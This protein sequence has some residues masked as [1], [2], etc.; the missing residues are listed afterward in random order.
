MN[1]G[2]YGGEM[3]QVLLDAVVFLPEEGIRTLRRE[4]CTCATATA[5]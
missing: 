3:G 2:A 4:I 5:C 1:A